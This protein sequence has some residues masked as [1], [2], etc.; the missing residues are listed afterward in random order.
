MFL[1]INMEINGIL[2]KSVVIFLTNILKNNKI[3]KYLYKNILKMASKKYKEMQ[4]NKEKNVGSDMPKYKQLIQMLSFRVVPAYYREI[5]KVA[6]KKKMTVSKLIRS[7][8]KDGM[9]RD[10]Q[11]SNQEDKDFRVD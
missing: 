2:L 1:S 3:T 4:S 8:I 11:L 6:D 9:K 5:E 7:Y 10:K